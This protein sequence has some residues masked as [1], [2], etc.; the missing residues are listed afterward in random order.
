MVESTVNQKNERDDLIVIDDVLAVKLADDTQENICKFDLYNI[1]RSNILFGRS[2]P[3]IRF[4]FAIKNNIVK[5]VYNVSA[6]IPSGSTMNP[7]YDNCSVLD[8]DDV[9]WEF[10]GTIAHPS[11]R[12]LYINKKIKLWDDLRTVFAIVKKG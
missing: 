7:E 8:E 1:V 6:W 4:V 3:K 5:E 10:V 2:E 9:S 12:N 11:F